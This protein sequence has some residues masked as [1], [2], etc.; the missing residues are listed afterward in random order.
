MRGKRPTPT[1]LKILKGVHKKDP[2]RINRNEPVPQSGHPEC[3]PSLDKEETK[4]WDWC[5][6]HLDYMGLLHKTDLAVIEAFAIAYT[7]MRR[8]AAEIRKYGVVI[9]SR[10][11]LKRSPYDIVCAAATEQARKL[12]V[13]MGLTPAERSRLVSNKPKDTGLPTA[14]SRA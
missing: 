9:A 13:E 5:V 4:M 2:K 12:L 14:R 3:P 1:A 8:A 7:R 6:H 10:D 11:G